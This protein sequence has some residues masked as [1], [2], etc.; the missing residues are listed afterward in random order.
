M[1][2][3]FL[4]QYFPPDPAPTGV[5]FAEIADE[6]RARG[7][8]VDFVDAGQ[9]YRASA[10]QNQ[11]GG[12]M[13]RELA[14][15]RRMVS[16][17][18]SRPR[19]DVVISG[20]SPPCLAVFADRVA[21]KH[22]ARHLHWAMD[23]Y[24]EIAV[25]LGEAKPGSL[26]A[27]ITG[28]LMGRAYRRCAAVI[29]LDADMAQVLARH[30]VKPEII[31]PWVFR[32]LGETVAAAGGRTREVGG[33]R[34]ELSERH[35]VSASDVAGGKTQ[36]GGFSCLYSGNL[37]RAHEYET[38]LRAQAVIESRGNTDMRLVVQGGGPGMAGARVLA[39]ELGLQRCEWRSYVPEEELVS[40]LLAHDVLAVTQRPETRG[41][42]WPSKLGLV[43]ALSRPI[44]FIGPTDGAIAA[45]L[46]GYPHAGVFAPG[47]QAGVAAWLEAKKGEVSSIS[48]VADPVRIR[49]EA[50]DAWM[51]VIESV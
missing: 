43:T 18:K 19:P 32:S 22:R 46:R 33:L 15:L 36:P 23:V 9:D 10:Q 31:R 17:G 13:K 8:E 37:G 45:D 29:A 41:L 28:W 51:R 2:I 7:H 11:K 24:P 25:A 44:L 40:S 16:I 39:E 12:R 6:C 14:A 30:R 48:Q 49:A 27:R 4:N 34:S 26:V 42:L 5:L 21:G 3:L 47:D 38:L 20:T 1:R 50:L 35:S